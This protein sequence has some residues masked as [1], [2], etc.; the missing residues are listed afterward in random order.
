M[1]KSCSETGCTKRDTK[2]SCAKAI[3]S[4]TH[5]SFPIQNIVKLSFLR[6]RP[7]YILFVV[8]EKVWSGSRMHLAFTPSK[9]II[10]HTTGA[11][12]VAASDCYL[13]HKCIR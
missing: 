8:A 11:Q 9:V 13:V 6:T 2:E 4:R 3:N 12:F 1:V 7:F 10:K 5:E